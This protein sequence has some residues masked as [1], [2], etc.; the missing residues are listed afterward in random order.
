MRQAFVMGYCRHAWQG[1]QTE[2]S[3]HDTY[4]QSSASLWP[5]ECR[6][7]HPFHEEVSMTQWIDSAQ[8]SVDMLSAHLLLTITL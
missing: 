7:L 6:Y 4:E 2:H 8:S 3:H 5:R 1:A